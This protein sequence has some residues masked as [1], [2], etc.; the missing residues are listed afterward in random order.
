MG[1]LYVR[2]I[3][4]SLLGLFQLLF[5]VRAILSWIPISAGIYDFFCTVTEP[6]IAPVRILFDRLGINTALPIDM[7]FL[8]TYLLMA[9]LSSIII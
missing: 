1:L 5:F 9:V 7:P 6:L 3:I 4:G 8:V 2:Y